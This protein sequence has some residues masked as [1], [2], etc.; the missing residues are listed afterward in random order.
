MN[1]KIEGSHKIQSFSCKNP[2]KTFLNL[3]VIYMHMGIY[4]LQVISCNT[5]NDIHDVLN[6]LI[7][8]SIKH[9]CN[10]DDLSEVI[11]YGILKGIPYENVFDVMAKKFDEGW[12]VKMI[13][14]SLY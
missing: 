5:N 2:A 8:Y 6:K 13:T 11:Y 3:Q 12:N 10:I 1:L 14:A 4:H 7:E 9:R